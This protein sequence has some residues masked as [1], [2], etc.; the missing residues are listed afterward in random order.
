MPRLRR[1]NHR[2]VERGMTGFS[3]FPMTNQPVRLLSG[4][5]LYATKNLS[6]R[7]TIDF[8]KESV[9]LSEIVGEYV[10]VHEERGRGHAHQCLCPFHDDR[11]PSMHLNDD[12]GLYYCFSCGAGGDVFHFVQQHEQC[13]FSEAVQHIVSMVGY[14]HTHLHW[15]HLFYNISNPQHHNVYSKPWTAKR[16][17]HAIPC[18][19]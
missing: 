1:V 9:L 11:N 19:L 8:V 7:E 6:L 2:T 3:M 14:H 15:H 16:H 13:S 12:K 5:R 17:Y 4:T 10:D 18:I